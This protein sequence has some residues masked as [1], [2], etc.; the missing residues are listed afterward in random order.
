[1]SM[2]ALHELSIAEA[3]LLL[4]SGGVSATALSRD[5]LGRIASVNPIIDAFV[6]VDAERALEDAARAD[7]ELAAGL[8]RGPLHGIPYALKDI[9]DVAGMAT[10]CHSHLMHG[11]VATQD[12]AVVERLLAGGAVLLGKLAT[13]EFALG[14]PSAELPFPPAR[15]PWNRERFTGG[16]SSGSAAAVAAGLT[17]LALGSDTSGSIRGPACYCGV[18]GLKPSYGRVSRRGVFPLSYALDHCGPITRTVEDAALAL[19]VIAGHDPYDIASSDRAVPDYRA[20]L[21]GDLR[22]LRIGFPRGFWSGMAA[23]TAEVLAN[24]DEVA[25]VVAGLGADIVEVKLPEF[26]WFS[27][28]GRLI[29]TAEGFAIHERALRERGADFGRY[30]YQRLMPGAAISAADLIRAQRMR[31]QLTMTLEREVFS[32][33]DALLCAGCLSPAPR[34]DAF[35][36]D[37][38]PAD[39]S[40]LTIPFNVTGHPALAVPSGFDR[41]AMPLGFQIVGRAFDEATVLRIGDAYQRATAH[42]RRRPPLDAPAPAGETPA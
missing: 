26:E 11:H 40:K 19:Q 38:P 27:A 7:R 12:S 31:L 32:R 3:G 17:G 36:K 20:A 25:A 29:M 18:V 23:T 33:C 9:Y 14:G 35:S 4:R 34:L 39:A 42:P 10:S 13:H 28:A 5:A 2:S 30:T 22:G 6:H 37:W 41:E 8:D 21:G 24:M 1:M 15:N 16:S